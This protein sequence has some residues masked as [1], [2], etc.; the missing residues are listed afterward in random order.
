VLE[1]ACRTLA[2]TLRLDGCA[3][4]EL[5]DGRALATAGFGLPAARALAPALGAALAGARGPLPVDE[6]TL[7]AEDCTVLER[8]GV[9]WLLPVGTRPT[10]AV[11]LLGRRI[12]GAWLG[13]LET[14]ELE[15][16]AEHLE[17]SLENSS[18]RRAAV[19]RGALDRELRI[20]GELQA[21]RLPRRAPAYPTLDCA[22]AARER[23][24]R[25]RLLRLHRDL[26]AR[27]HARRRRRGR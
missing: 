8:A 3:A 26:A 7:G 11:L 19:T 24:R 5:E 18:L 15:R 2:E 17:V 1:E 14:R 23:A 9:R 6:A 27:F 13:R 25:R 10:R 21:H 4:I 22:A 16:F 20:A 12:A